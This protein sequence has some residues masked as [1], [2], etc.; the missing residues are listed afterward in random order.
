MLWAVTS[1]EYA[2]A[3]PAV[4]C[5]PEPVRAGALPSSTLL[6][7]AGRM[8]LDPDVPDPLSRLVMKAASRQVNRRQFVVRIILG[9]FFF[10]WLH[11]LLSLSRQ[12]RNS[13]RTLR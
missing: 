4:R 3:P 12:N 13:W 1:Y 7:R 11:Y 9:N 8:K 10:V 6:Q 5:S 2:D